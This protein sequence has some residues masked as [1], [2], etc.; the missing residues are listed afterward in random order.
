MVWKGGVMFSKVIL[1]IYLL[2]SRRRLGNEGGVERCIDS[3]YRQVS[4]KFV[5]VTT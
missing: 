2:E 5:T 3:Q 4:S 1:P